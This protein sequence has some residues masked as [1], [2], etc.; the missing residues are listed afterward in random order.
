M[1]GEPQDSDIELARA[2]YEAYTQQSLSKEAFLRSKNIDKEIRRAKKS[3][4]THQ[5]KLLILGATASKSRAV[6]P[7]RR[8][9]PFSL[10]PARRA[11]I[12]FYRI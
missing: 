10:L 11:R 1:D 9:A 8:L 5:F 3:D 7:S 12:V 6:A 4:A 2:E